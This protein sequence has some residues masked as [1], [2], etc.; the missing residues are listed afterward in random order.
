MQISCQNKSFSR[1]R[2]NPVAAPNSSGVRVASRLISF[3]APS[4]GCWTSRQHYYF[5]RLLKP[6]AQTRSTLICQSVIRLSLHKTTC[7]APSADTIIEP[8]VRSP[9]PPGFA[10]I[11]ERYHLFW[12]HLF[13]LCN[14]THGTTLVNSVGVAHYFI[15][16][17]EGDANEYT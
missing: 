17:S 10:Y 1:G 9:P 12:S 3:L 7:C 14:A 13:V 4:N 16:Y 11:R 15:V 8:Y 6:N 5:Y 2:S